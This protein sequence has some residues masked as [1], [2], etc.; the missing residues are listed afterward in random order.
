M[1]YKRAVMTLIMVMETHSEQVV[2]LEGQ[3]IW[4]HIPKSAHED[5]MASN[6]RG[7]RTRPD[8]QAI[9]GETYTRESFDLEPHWFILICPQSVFKIHPL[10]DRVLARILRATPAHVHIVVTGG[11][12]D[13][14]TSVYK[15]RLYSAADAYDDDDE[16]DS[17]KGPEKISEQAHR[18]QKIRLRSRIHII[19]RGR[20]NLSHSCRWQRWSPPIPSMVPD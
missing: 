14:W 15:D 3:G 13:A 16:Y 5:L 7:Y 18:S 9:M 19:P 8:V 20:Q 2:L 12:R 6:F 10:F 1:T 4:Y 17:S 11:H